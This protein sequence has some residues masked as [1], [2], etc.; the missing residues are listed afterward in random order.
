MALT[1]LFYGRLMSTFL[2]LAN[3]LVEL[4]DIS[5]T[6]LTTLQSVTGTNLRVKNWIINSWIDIQNLHNDWAFL[7]QDLSFATSSSQSYTL[8]AMSATNLR[9]YDQT[10]LRIY[11]TAN[12]VSDEQPLTYMDWDSF[13]DTYLFGPRQ[14]GRPVIFSVDPATKTLYL[15]ANPGTGFTI[16]GYYYR[17]PVTLSADADEPACPS[18]YQ[19]AIPYRAL[20]KNAGFEAA[21][22]VKQEA[23]ENYGPLINDM[24]VDQLPELMMEGS[25]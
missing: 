20:M 16:V 10:S 17:T 25:L 15:S 19:M 4:A 22:E 8:A 24:R 7:R 6:P 21:A 2:Q 14:S 23:K 11:T 5:N 9:Q 12:G 18:G 1:G 3:A 13:K